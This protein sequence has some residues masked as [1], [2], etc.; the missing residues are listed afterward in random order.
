MAASR[1][2]IELK[3]RGP[4]DPN[5]SK[6]AAVLSAYFHA[7]HMR[8]FRQ[9]LWKRLAIGGLVWVLA[10]TLTSEISRSAF[11]GGV[12]VLVMVGG[13]AA[14]AEWRAAEQLHEL[15]RG[16]ARSF[17]AIRSLHPAARREIDSPG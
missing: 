16:P 14:V 8:T 1:Q 9:L 13:G 15:L 7:E 17:T 10:A 12:A 6:T 4:G 5:G 3:A 11:V 2:I